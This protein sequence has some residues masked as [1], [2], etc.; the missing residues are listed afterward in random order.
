MNKKKTYIITGL[1]T[2][3]LLVSALLYKQLANGFEQEEAFKP[4]SESELAKEEA[5]V[6]ETP[7]FYC[8]HT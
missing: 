3:L 8:L 1:F 6:P 2:A 4:Q 5:G 7:L